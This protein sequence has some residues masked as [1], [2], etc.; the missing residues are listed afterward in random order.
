MPAGPVEDWRD[1][2]MDPQLNT[3]GFFKTISAP[4]VGTYRYPGFPWKFSKTPLRVTHPPCM[5]G[6]D[7]EYVYREVI[8]LSDREIEALE[9]KNVIGDLT[10]DWAG[11]PPDHVIEE[12]DPGVFVL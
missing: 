10:Y 1:A 8:G 6:E 11:P 5:L 7:N 2:L 4:D 12:L 3:R 9:R